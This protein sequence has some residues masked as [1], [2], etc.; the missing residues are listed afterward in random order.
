[1]VAIAWM[2]SSLVLVAVFTATMASMLTAEKLGVQKTIQKPEDLRGLSIGTAANTTATQYAE[3]NHLN[4]RTL[5]GDQLLPALRD[6]KFDAVIND[7]PILLY[8]THT[9]YPNQLTVL[10]IHLDEE[11]YGFGVKEGSSLRESINRS[12]LRRLADPHWNEILRQYLG[13]S[14]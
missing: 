8:E 11:F 12:L 2:F 6:G 1:V 14:E 5:P 7:A 3:T 4:F 9:M 10:P 13:E